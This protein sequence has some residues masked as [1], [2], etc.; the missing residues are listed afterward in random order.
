[1]AG[2]TKKRKKSK[3][4]Y[5]FWTEFLLIESIKKKF[6]LK[7]LACSIESEPGHLINS[8]SIISGEGAK[9]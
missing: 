6:E 9:S 2:T 7:N 3:K 8:Q 1:M 4:E 5:I